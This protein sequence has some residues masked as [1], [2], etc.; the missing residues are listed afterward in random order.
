MWW[1]CKPWMDKVKAQKWIKNEWWRMWSKHIIYGGIYHY[2][3]IYEHSIYI[4]VTIIQHSPGSMCTK[5]LFRKKC[6]PDKPKTRSMLM[7]FYNSTSI[8][9]NS[10]FPYLMHHLADFFSMFVL[11]NLLA[12]L[13]FTSRICERRRMK[14]EY[15]RKRLD[16]LD[17]CRNSTFNSIRRITS[18]GQFFV[19]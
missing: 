13:L 4:K 2:T 15:E 10:R 3:D 8:V 7:A 11:S 16:R 17:P 12:S 1:W 19:A 5:P 6:Y 18:K 9:F 14:G